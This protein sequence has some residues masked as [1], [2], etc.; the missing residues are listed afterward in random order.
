MLVGREFTA[1]DTASAPPVLIINER[2]K[3]KLWPSS[4]PV[5]QTF[6]ANGTTFLVVGIARDTKYRSLREAPRM[7]FYQPLAQSYEASVNLVVSS[8]LSREATTS[9]IRDAVRSVDPA[10][11]LYNVHTM[12]EH[13]DQSLYLDRL[14]AQLLGWLAGLALAL[15]AVGLYGVVAYDVTQRTREV[16]IRLAL[17]AEPAAIV[18]MLVGGGARLALAGLAI[19]TALAFWLTRTIASQLYGITPYDPIALGG[20]AVV[21]L[22]V[23][24]AATYVPARR[25]MRIDAVLAIRAE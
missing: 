19:G 15:A 13:V 22:A 17:G 23:A 14:R 10:M 21:L 8:A 9:E 11:P 7:T 1:A 3:A 2:M 20:A 4:D 5:G 12:T 18:R 24:L 16:G 25:A 6:T